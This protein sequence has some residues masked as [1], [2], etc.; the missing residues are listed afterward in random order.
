MERLEG[1]EIVGLSL[2]VF[3]IGKLPMGMRLAETQSDKPLPPPFDIRPTLAKVWKVPM[4][5]FDAPEEETAE[6]PDTIN[7]EAERRKRQA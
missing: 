5:F 7:F 4:Y 6:K 1:R 3:R 2:I